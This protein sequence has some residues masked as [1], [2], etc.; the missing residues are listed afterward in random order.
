MMRPV[1]PKIRGVIHESA[2]LADEVGDRESY[3]FLRSALQEHPGSSEIHFVAGTAARAIGE[4]DEA[5]ELTQRGAE[6]AWDDPERLTWAA[7][8]ILNL[9]EPKKAEKWAK[10]VGE[11]A[12]PE[13]F[14]FTADFAMLI[15]R[16]ALVHDEVGKAEEMFK[17]GFEIEPGGIG[18]ATELGAL[19]ERQGRRDEAV[20]VVEEGLA[21]QPDDA[22]LIALR[23]RLRQTATR[24][25]A[26]T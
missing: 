2:R 20:K 21:H 25:R 18:N 24:P 22:R 11:I 13:E 23:D 7:T 14:G 15:G 16:L 8:T 10:R 17:V 19:L 26:D 6:L 5:T 9:G 1:D 3:D 12:D 4:F